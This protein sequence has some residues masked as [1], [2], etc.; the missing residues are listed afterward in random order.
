MRIATLFIFF[1]C[2]CFTFIVSVFSLGVRQM[3]L[4]STADTDKIHAREKMLFHVIASSNF[5]G[6]TE[7]Q[8]NISIDHTL[9]EPRGRMKGRSITL[10][11]LVARD[12]E[13]LKLFIHEL[14][15]FVDIYVFNSID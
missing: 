8:L 15:H 5:Y 7:E 10:S 2:L 14:S 3:T 12:A 13:F 1:S 9:V 6:F 11:S 4:S